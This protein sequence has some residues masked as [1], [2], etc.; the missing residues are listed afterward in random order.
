MIQI[1]GKADL[2]NLIWFIIVAGCSATA[3]VSY[4]SS[5]RNLPNGSHRVHTQTYVCEPVDKCCVNTDPATPLIRRAQINNHGMGYYSQHRI[6]NLRVLIRD[7][8]HSA[9]MT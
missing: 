4:P 5:L 7:L 2:N 9:R 3:S 1:E 8:I 6:N